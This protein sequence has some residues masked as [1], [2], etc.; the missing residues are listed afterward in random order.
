M[1]YFF[2]FLVAAWVLSSQRIV[3]DDPVLPGGAFPAS[4]Y[5]A[6]WTKS[7]FAVATAD[8]SQDTSPDYILV[9]IANVAGVSYASVLETKIPQN[10]FL[11][12]TDKANQGM[13]LTSIS[14]S[15]D[16]KDTYAVMQKDG[17]PI[18]LK[19]QQVAATAGAPG[20]PSMAAPTMPSI[21]SPPQI[22]TPS[23]FPN[24]QSRRPFPRFHRSPIN[25]PPQVSPQQLQ[26]YQAAPPPPQ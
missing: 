12:S 11:V 25:L 17:Q 2:Y 7:P 9:G 14:H 21:M 20:G 4:R 19:L 22:S 3:A 10:H 16:G 6:L 8:M 23:S 13:L 26:P 24:A 15:A 18:T 5:E 1:K